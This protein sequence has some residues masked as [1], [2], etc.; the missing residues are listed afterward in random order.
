MSG[1]MVLG[2]VVILLL[3][4]S[5]L[6]SASEVALFGL[7][8]SDRES[9]S[10]S[11]SSAAARVLKLLDKPRELLAVI[12]IANNLVNILIIILSTLL[13][14]EVFQ[15]TALST[16]AQFVIQIVG[17]TLIILLFG[18]VIPKVYA[19]RNGLLVGKLMSAPLLVL[20]VIFRAPAKL[21]VSSSGFIERR[22]KKHDET[23]SVDQLEHALEITTSEHN[24]DEQEQ[25]ILEGIVRFGNTDVKQIM[26]PR[27]D[28]TA[29][30]I[31]MT[32]KE[33]T[34]GIYESGYSR[35]P[36]FK[37]SFDQVEGVLY[38]KDL[39]RYLGEAD[40]FNWQT[41]IRPGF[42]VPENRK[43]DDLLKDFQGRKMHMA[44][45]V[46][47]YGGSSGIVTLE[48]VLEEII[49]EITD[50]FDE[51]EVNY[52][53]IDD[54]TFI[55]DGK[56]PLIDVYRILDIEGDEFEAQKGESDTLAGFLL[57]ISSK[58]M[59]KNERVQFGD[60][61][62]TVESA[63]K[64]RVKQVKVYRKVVENAGGEQ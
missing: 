29:F 44:I 41:L 48:D 54:Q 55:F 5:A 59:K 18:E 34:D 37:N 9:L 52:K 47:E 53:Q 11:K 57:E 63:D 39:I 10:V 42:F 3:V 50:E 13:T 6:V 28:V 36:V 46:D 20:S 56:T 38:A 23:I 64:R 30:D 43:I 25:R 60:F 62:L 19:T 35:I 51:D 40:D 17:V 26:T 14:E 1:Q 22:L 16:T 8:P 58:I 49:G 15:N 32:F 24:P 33:V 27:V 31:E 61:V 21:L 2:V 7:K 4:C 12:L 45:V